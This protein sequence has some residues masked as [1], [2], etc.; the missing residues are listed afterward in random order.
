MKACRRHTDLNH[1]AEERIDQMRYNIT[2]HTRTPAL[3]CSVIFREGIERLG[4]GLDG[5][6]IGAMMTWD[7]DLIHNQQYLKVLRFLPLSKQ[8]NYI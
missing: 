3:S 8:P 5:V 1:L 7:P 6:Y 4:G 2:L